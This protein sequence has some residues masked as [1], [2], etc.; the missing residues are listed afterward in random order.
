M[1]TENRYDKGAHI[2]RVKNVLRFPFINLK[3]G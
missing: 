3:F 2:Q 1:K